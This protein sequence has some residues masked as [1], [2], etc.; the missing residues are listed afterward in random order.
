MANIYTL[1]RQGDFIKEFKIYCNSR[2]IESHPTLEAMNAFSKEAWEEFIAWVDFRKRYTYE[3]IISWGW[4]EEEIRNYFP[5][6]WGI[7]N[8]D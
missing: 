2:D 3:E 5:F 1:H 6:E 7:R 8:E 4:D